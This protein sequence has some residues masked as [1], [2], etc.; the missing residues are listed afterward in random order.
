M[1]VLLFAF[2]VVVAMTQNDKTSRPSS[3]CL[4]DP[5]RVGNSKFA[6]RLSLASQLPQGSGCTQ[7]CVHSKNLWELAC[8]RWRQFNQRKANSPCTNGSS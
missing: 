2:F 5:L 8:Q 3:A 4:R 1:K 7:M 6:V